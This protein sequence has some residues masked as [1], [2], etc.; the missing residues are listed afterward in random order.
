MELPKAIHDLEFNHGS[1]YGPEE[2]A[3]L[4]EVLAAGAPS[5]GA[6]VKKF[7]ETFAA[8]CGAQY[9]LAVT[10][11]TAG[12]Q[13][14][15]IAA[16]VG[17]GDE[18]IT[19]TI[20]WI[21]TANAAAAQGAQVVFA[22]VDPRTLN[23]SGDSIAEKITDRTKVILLVHLYGQCC[24]MDPIL[25]L[26]RKRG[27]LVVE[28]CAHA[29]GAEYKGRRVGGLGDIS[30]FSF[31]QQ[32]NMV[33]LGEGGMVTTNRRDLYERTL[34]FRS[35]CCL[36]YD[37]KGKYLPI[38]ESKAPM[39]KRYWYLDFDNVG[40]NF[41]MTDAQAAVGL[42][43]L[44]KLDGFNA[45]RIEIA[46][47]Y[48][49]RLRGIRGLTT[50]YVSPNV[51]HVFH[52]YCVLIE[53]EFRRS[54]EEF[55]WELYT[56]KRIKVWS[57]YMPIHLTTAYRQLGHAEGECPVAEALFHRYVSLPIHPRM[58]EETITYVTDSVRELA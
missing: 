16:G 12:L 19:T 9:G 21:S 13:L 40:F 54:K 57:H 36:T 24:D 37:P 42:V 4:R 1:I 22:D 27:I 45:R 7:E 8:Y 51:K 32:K 28:D 55:M 15:M 47:L 58:T 10:S 11:A 34:S 38:D 49:D 56:A 6:K 25:E 29:P 53:P 46:N 41:R 35:L 20:S 26:A 14:A 3:A 48:C 44:A 52:I 23:L 5:C 17:P 31:H 18:V 39:G 50:P 30:V 33:T 2:E 43:Q